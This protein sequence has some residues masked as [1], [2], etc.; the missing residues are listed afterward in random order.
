MGEQLLQDIEV[1]AE[2]DTYYA[3]AEYAYKL[4]CV[5]PEVNDKGVVDLS[6]G[7]VTR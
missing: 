6:I 4:S 1:L 7:D 5:K 2:I 3:R